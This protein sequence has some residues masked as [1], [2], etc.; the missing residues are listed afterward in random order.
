MN[1]ELKKINR[2]IVFYS[3][4]RPRNMN[5]EEHRKLLDELFDKKRRLLAN[6]PTPK[7]DR[8]QC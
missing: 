3:H 4:T 2:R 6:E 1:S 5:R 7:I 8:R